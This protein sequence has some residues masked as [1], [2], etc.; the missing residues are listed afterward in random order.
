MVKK[1]GLDVERGIPDFTGDGDCC[2]VTTFLPTVSGVNVTCLMTLLR[3]DPSG[4]DGTLGRCLFKSGLGELVC[5]KDVAPRA[6]DGFL[7]LKLGYRSIDLSL[8]TLPG[9]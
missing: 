7:A 1:P 8:S 5:E 3:S 9:L 2:A 6:A 4:V